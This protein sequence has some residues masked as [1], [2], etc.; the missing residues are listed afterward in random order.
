[1]KRVWSL[2]IVL[3][4]ALLNAVTAQNKTI[5]SKGF[6]VLAADGKFKPFEFN[7]HALGDNE[8]LIETL[9]ASICHSDIHHVH[10]DWGKE[11]FPMVPGHEIAGRVSKVGKNVTKFKVGDYAG[12]GCMV[13]SCG[14]CDFCK[15]G[16]EQYC[17]DVVLTYHDKDQFHDNEVT[18]GG[19]SNNIVLTENFAI[20]L[21]ANT[22]MKKVAPL[23]CAGITT[24]SPIHYAQVKKGDKVGVAGFG[25]LGHMAVQYA[26]K[27]GAEVT[28]F[29]ITEEKRAD[30]KRLGAV[31]YVN[32]N[33]PEDLKGLDNSLNFIISTI[34]A[35]YDP[36][37]YLKMLKIDGQMAFVG[38]PP[39]AK[40]PIIPIDKL[41]WQGN[42][43]V[44]GS[45]IGGIKET[46]EMLD[47]S[48]A[49]NIY[50][51]VEIIPATSKAIEVAYQNVL[52][53]KVK[54]RYVIDMKTLK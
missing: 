18:Q 20:K 12:V 49:N 27:I 32:V 6:A 46:Q 53:G 22:D 11:E 33:N 29:D 44:F 31:K 1:M 13:N 50:P 9:Y 21:P 24:Y 37:I 4:M 2:T 7:R 15:A 35:S 10:G 5:P 14:K 38:L 17:K 43:K 28:V 8:I 26:V 41:I 47:Y 48:I 36:N 52:D 25:G 42:R 23:L 16:L 3:V 51:E 30:A 19:Y 54:F 45:Q 39:Y 40:M 34:P